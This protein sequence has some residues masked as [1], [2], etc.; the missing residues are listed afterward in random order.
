M[1]TPEPKFKIFE[2]VRAVGP[3]GAV[4]LGFIK[5]ITRERE[6]WQYKVESPSMDGNHVLSDYPETALEPTPKPKLKSTWEAW[7]VVLGEQLQMRINEW[8][9]DVPSQT[10][11]PV[12]AREV[13]VSKWC[14]ILSKQLLHELNPPKK[15]K[16]WILVR[17]WM[18]HLQ[19]EINAKTELPVQEINPT[20]ISAILVEVWEQTFRAIWEKEVALNLGRPP[21]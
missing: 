14:R 16:P 1:N 7:A 18:A 12:R 8:Q 11:Y 2:H 19:C 6:E 13:E 4:Q 10:V 20:N 15:V 3:D 17:L 21:R 9:M 5:K